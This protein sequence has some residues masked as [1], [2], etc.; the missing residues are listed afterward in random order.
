MSHPEIF[1]VHHCRIS[2]SSQA[3]IIR[4]IQERSL[5]NGTF[6]PRA[7]LQP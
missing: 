5:E 2:L 1:N 3:A 4:I 7:V 6:F